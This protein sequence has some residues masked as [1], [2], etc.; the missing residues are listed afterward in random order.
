MAN[1][2]PADFPAIKTELLDPHYGPIIAANPTA[3]AQN[4]A[5]AAELNKTPSWKAGDVVFRSNLRRVD[6]LKAIVGTEYLALTQAQ[7]DLLSTI[8]LEAQLDVNDP[9]VRAQLAGIFAAGTATRTAINQAARRAC[10]RLEA[11]LTRPDATIEG[12]DV[13]AARAS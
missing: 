8:L 6:V 11:L 9:D 5:L 1:I 10:S 2:T 12:W 4:Y 7:R 3:D 13:A